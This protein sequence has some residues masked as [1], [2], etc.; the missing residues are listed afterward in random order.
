MRVNSL[1][2]QIGLACL[3]VGS[4]LVWAHKSASLPALFRRQNA[5]PN[6]QSCSVS[7]K[8]ADTCCIPEFGLFALTLQWNPKVGASDAFTIH[9]LW[10]DGCRGERAPSD[11]CDSS[12]KYKDVGDLIKSKDSSLYEDMNKYW[13]SDNGNNNRFWTHEWGKHGTCVSTLNP[14]CYGNSFKSGQDVQ[15]YF[16]D[17]IALYKQYN[18]YDAFVKEGLK[19]GNS[20]SADQFNK[21]ANK[22]LGR[23]VTLSCDDGRLN[24]VMLY[25]TVSGRSF[26]LADPPRSGNRG[27]GGQVQWVTKSGNKTNS[28]NGGDATRMHVNYYQHTL[29]TLLFMSLVSLLVFI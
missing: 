16:S 12:R 18:L 27:C 11:G 20:A 9:G 28:N 6:I 21:A 10:P 24:E 1:I 4:P 19:P 22:T 17:T 25:F 2:S 14:K 3:L 5:C 7:A 8:N 29:M 23:A 15:D 13:P 26:K